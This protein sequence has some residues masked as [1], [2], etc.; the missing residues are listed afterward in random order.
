[1]MKS[2]AAKIAY[3]L[4]LVLVGTVLWGVSAKLSPAL[5]HSVLVSSDPKIG[6][7]VAPGPRDLILT[8]DSR[9]DSHR[10]RIFMTYPDDS[11][12]TLTPTLGKTQGTLVVHVDDLPQGQIYLNYE[13]L[14][15]DGHIARGVVKFTVAKP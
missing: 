3:G 10:S 13:V 15:V 7:I 9:V 14:S 8:F 5:A 4:A 2:Y 11:R 1:M 6:D 12:H